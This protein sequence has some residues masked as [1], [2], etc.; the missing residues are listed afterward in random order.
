[1]E[2]HPRSHRV[3]P[4]GQSRSERTEPE[5]VSEPI[6]KLAGGSD[7]IGLTINACGS[8]GEVWPCLDR[9][10]CVSHAKEDRELSV[11]RVVEAD[12]RR[13]NDIRERVRGNELCEA[14][15][16][17]SSIIKSVR[18]GKGI[19]N[20]LHRRDRLQPH[21]EIWDV[22]NCCRGWLR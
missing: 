15:S 12:A 10:R 9:T 22:L 17:C 5:L 1:M 11:K 6:R 2:S 14:R 20:W 18:D 19:E 3:L 8:T 16:G 21:E 4:F 13:V 7:R